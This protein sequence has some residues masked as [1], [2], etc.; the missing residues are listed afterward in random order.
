MLLT[1]VA[2]AFLCAC[3]ASFNKG[4]VIICTDSFTAD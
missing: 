4:A 2:I 1:P 3:D